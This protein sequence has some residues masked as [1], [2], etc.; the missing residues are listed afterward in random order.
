MT[1]GLTRNDGELE[2]SSKSI[3]GFFSQRQNIFSPAMWRMLF[4]IMRFNIFATDVL[5]PSYAFKDESIGS[6]LHRNRYSAAF[7][8]NYLIPLASSL[9]VNDTNSVPDEMPA[10][11]LVRY[12]WTHHMLNTFKTTLQWLTIKGGCYQYVEKILKGSPAERLH[13]KTRVTQVRREGEQV[14]LDL[15]TGEREIFDRVIIATHAPD[16]LRLRGSDATTEEASIL[17]TFRTITGTVAVH[18][19]LSVCTTALPAFKS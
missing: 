13:T 10:I 4:D 8:D 15:G 7:K 12:F 16:A 3:S 14:V 9:W 11:M 19:D 18:S 17:G 6:Y 1:F 5:E 2:W